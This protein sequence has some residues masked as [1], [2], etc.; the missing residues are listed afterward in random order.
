MPIYV[1]KCTEGHRFESLIPMAAASPNCPSCDRPARKVPTTVGIGV[2]R[3]GS[4]PTPDGFT[5]GRLWREAFA[6]KPEKVRREIEFRER[7]A[8]SGTRESPSPDRNLTSP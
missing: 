4:R 2:G 8:R 3:G 5:P 7:L 6:G 1:F